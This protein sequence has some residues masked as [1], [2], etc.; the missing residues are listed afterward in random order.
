[1]AERPILFSGPMVLALLAERKTVTRRVMK[2]Q[3][4]PCAYA[5][6]K[7]ALNGQVIEGNPAVLGQC[8][9][10]QPGGRL[11]VRETLKRGER[12][13]WYYAADNTPVQLPQGHPSVPAMLSWA[14]HKE[15]NTCVSSHMPRW[16]SRLT[17]G[18][19]S[20]RVE[21]LHDITETDAVRE[22]VERYLEVPYG[23]RNYETSPVY[24]DVSY[25]LTAR[26]SFASLWRSINGAESW[27]AN[28]WVWRVEF[29]KVEVKRG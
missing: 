23:W 15:G 1:M 12:G 8:P 25:H 28:P 7:N 17:L 26:D 27:A 3:P 9:Y 21:R 6:G 11:W 4:E 14:H 16:A 5:P 2:P 22:G 13:A 19:V 18:V 29:R 20:V 10:G 24:E